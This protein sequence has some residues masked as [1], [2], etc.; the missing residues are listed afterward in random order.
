MPQPGT[1][2]TATETDSLV[3]M[4]SHSSAEPTARPSG[5]Q[6]QQA[7]RDLGSDR[8][9]LAERLA[10][11]W[12]L[13]PLSALIVAGFVATPAIQSD[14]PRNAVVGLLIAGCIVL[15]FAYQR[16]SGVRVGRIGARGGALLVGLLVTT[17]LLLSTS[18]G[19]VASVTPWSALAPA[20]VCFVMVLIGGQRFDRLYRENLSRGH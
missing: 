12:W 7:L 6:A 1:W 2:L 19:L 10:A 9:A 16:L 17:L 15:L 8:A 13:Y 4:E 3:D 18:Y 5:T 11:S 20:V 14:E